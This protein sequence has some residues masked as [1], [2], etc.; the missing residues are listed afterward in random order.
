MKFEIVNNA[1]NEEKPIK[2]H[3]EVMPE[4][5][6]LNLF[7]NGIAVAYVGNLTGILKIVK[8]SD[9]DRKKLELCGIPFE[10]GGIKV[11]RF[12]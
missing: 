1:V 3:L 4:S 11:E 5:G 2:A 12:T 8:I 9:E 10:D 6:C 7:F